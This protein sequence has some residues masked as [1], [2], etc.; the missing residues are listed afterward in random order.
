MKTI[1]TCANCARG[2]VAPRV[3]PVPAV[4]L[5]LILIPALCGGCERLSY[6]VY[7]G[8][9]SPQAE[10]DNSDPA[11]F[12]ELALSAPLRHQ[13]LAVYPLK[14]RDA[15]AFDNFL[16]LQEALEQKVASVLE[17]GRVN[18]LH[19]ENRGSRPVFVHAGDIVRGGKQDRMIPNDMI[20]PPHSGK[21]AVESFCVES[22]RWTWR[23]NES[24]AAFNASNNLAYGNRAK[25]ASRLQSDQSGVWSAVA[26]KQNSL[27]RKIGSSVRDPRSTSSLELTLQNEKVKK[28]VEQYERALLD[29]P[30]E[31]PD[32]VGVAIVT[33]GPVYGADVYCSR[34]LF[35]KLWPKLLKG[36]AVEAV[37]ASHADPA[38]QVAAT[39]KDL[40]DMISRARAGRRTRRGIHQSLDLKI[41]T[42]GRYRLFRTVDTIRNAS[43]HDCYVVD[44]DLVRT[45]RKRKRP[46][47]G[48]LD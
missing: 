3:P 19:I 43:L 24:A 33:S 26:A 10:P 17:V 2:S 8:H 31:H 45:E 5:L 40:Q 20:L 9:A 32:A 7:R 39:A 13:N 1:A 12:V 22:G 38:G 14:G 25:I 37:T 46:L 30:R 11:P 28:A 23:G 18:E 35:R 15:L 48:G 42:S 47:K 44:P 34:T 27:S 6:H 4:G 21:V 29:L 36:I 41:R 16:T